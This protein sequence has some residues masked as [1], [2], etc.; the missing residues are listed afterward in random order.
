VNLDEDIV[1]RTFRA[2]DFDLLLEGLLAEIEAW[3]YRVTKIY[4]ID[5]IYDR[6]AQG[7]DVAIGFR[8]YKIVEFCNLITC[9]ELISTNLLAGVFMPARYA[10]FQSK[11][12][13]RI[14]IAF[15]KPVAFVRPF[16]SE[17]LTKIAAKLTEDMISVVDGI[18]Y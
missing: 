1:R 5:N 16:E 7:I 11:D 3:N 2:E 10:V 18:V 17:P 13:A 15:V 6:Q 4:D 9:N 8:R 14:N 12:D